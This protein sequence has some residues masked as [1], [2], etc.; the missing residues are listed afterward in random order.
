MVNQLLTE[1]ETRIQHWRQAL[2]DALGP[3]IRV[4][5]DMIPE[6]AW[7]TGP[8]PP[9]PELGATEAQ[10][11]VHRS[12]QH[13]IAVFA[14]PEHPLVVFD[15]LQ[16]ADTPSLALMEV[17]CADPDSRSLLMIGAYRDN[18]VSA[19]HPLILTLHRLREAGARLHTRYCW[20]R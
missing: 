14:R 1:Q 10:D 11:R 15:D 18:E 9:V 3:N 6:V 12:F 8:Q 20:G 5:I 13:F 16:W 7:I 4:I 17:L 2:L 19:S